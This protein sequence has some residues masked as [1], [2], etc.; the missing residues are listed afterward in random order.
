M[1]LSK[2][3]A[4]M[5]FQHFSYDEIVIVCFKQFRQKLKGGR[6]QLLYR[7][8]VISPNHNYSSDKDNYKDYPTSHVYVRGQQIKCYE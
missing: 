5:S 8:G 7:F 2:L 4:A 3:F 6:S 1:F